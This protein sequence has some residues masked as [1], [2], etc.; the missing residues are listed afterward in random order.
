MFRPIMNGH[1]LSKVAQQRGA[2]D[3]PDTPWRMI[4]V[5][6]KSNILGYHLYRFRIGRGDG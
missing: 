6:V 3:I 5:I 1:S 4:V 2:L